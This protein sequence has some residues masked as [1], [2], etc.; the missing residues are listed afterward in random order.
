MSATGTT[1]NLGLPVWNGGDKPTMGDFNSA[2]SKLDA[3]GVPVLTGSGNAR[4]RQFKFANGLL[5]DIGRNTYA[6]VITAAYGGIYQNNV[7]QSFPSGNGTFIEPPE[8]S[9]SLSSTGIIWTTLKGAGITA[10]GFEY[11]LIS[12]VSI[13]SAIT[14]VLSYIAI[15]RWK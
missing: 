6:A 9:M 12:P 13:S 11:Y 4:A 14:V 2:F 7:S 10:T 5:I 1:T 3:D 15:G 8:V